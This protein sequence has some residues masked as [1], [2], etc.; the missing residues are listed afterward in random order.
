MEELA[1]IWAYLKAMPSS[2]AHGFTPEGQAMLEHIECPPEALLVLTRAA[3]QWVALHPRWELYCF[4]MPELVEAWDF[5]TGWP[6]K[7]HLVRLQ[8]DRKVAYRCKAKILEAAARYVGKRCPDLT[9]ELTWRFTQNLNSF[10]AHLDE[11]EKA[12]QAGQ[13]H[14]FWEHLYKVYAQY[15]DIPCTSSKEV[16]ERVTYDDGIDLGDDPDDDD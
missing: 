13:R 16:W 10:R 5:A 14:K 11:F 8:A 9:P 3:P 2:R 4:T 1:G 15:K 7:D 6:I 12:A